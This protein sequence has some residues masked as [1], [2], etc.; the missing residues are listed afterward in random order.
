MEPLNVTEKIT[1]VWEKED[2]KVILTYQIPC[3]LLYLPEATHKIYIYTV[4]KETE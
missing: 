1:Q 3:M 2:V 4:W